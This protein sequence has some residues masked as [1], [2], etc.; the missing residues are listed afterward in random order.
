M[1]CFEHSDYLFFFNIVPKGIIIL[2]CYAADFFSKKTYIYVFF[3]WFH[4]FIYSFIYLFIFQFTRVLNTEN[5]RLLNFTLK[6]VNNIDIAHS[7]YLGCLWPDALHHQAISSHG[8]DL[9][10]PEYSD[11]STRRFNILLY[12]TYTG[13]DG[14]NKIRNSSLKNCGYA[15]YIGLSKCNL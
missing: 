3:C 15:Y 1:N 12:D 7:Q 2:N 13:W 9:I 5:Y 11:F 6:E 10:I 8:I 4:L 14:V